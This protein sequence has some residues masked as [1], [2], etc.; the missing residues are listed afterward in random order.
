MPALASTGLD[1]HP[2]CLGGNVFGWTADEDASFAVLDRYV[3]AG[4]TFV[5]TA[6]VYSSWVPDH[7]GG[8]SEAVLGRWLAA[9]GGREDLVIATKVG[10]HFKADLA[11]LRPE[12]ILRACDASLERLGVETIDLY[13]QHR[14]DEDVPLQESLGAFD[15]LVRA[16]KIKHV[17][18]SNFSA[19]RLREAVAV[20]QEHGYA[21]ISVLQPQYNLLDRAGFEGELQDVCVEHGIAVVPFY[22]LAMGFLTG[23][24]T[25]ESEAA[26]MGTPR[27]KGAIKTYGGQERSWA[28]LD[29]LRAVAAEHGTSVSAVALAW[30][31]ARDAVVA[32]IA[33][34]RTV[35]QLEELLPMAELQ[36]RDEDLAALDAASAG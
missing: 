12:S 29:A 4:G 11:N 28:T 2:L 35:E 8:E 19:A 25:R 18:L 14:D 16:G 10:M 13:Y 34:A 36:L 22:G 6:D 24:Y 5:D 23:K 31:R 17:G 26:D 1:V 30:L 32:P 33:S 9:R 27:A 21:P 7:P 20:T 3:A 15:E